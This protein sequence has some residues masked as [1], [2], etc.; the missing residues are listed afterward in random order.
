MAGSFQ[1]GNAELRMEN[2]GT[3]TQMDANKPGRKDTKCG[4]PRAQGTQRGDLAG[5]SGWQ[6][7]LNEEC[8]V[9]SAE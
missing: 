1:M 7:H 3:R 5:S 6:D 9:K 4:K 2:E 8:K